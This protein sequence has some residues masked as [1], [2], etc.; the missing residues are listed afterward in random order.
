MVYLP[1]EQWKVLIT[2]AHEGYTTWEEYEENQ[3][4]ITRNNRCTSASR[5]Y[6]PRE[7]PALLQGLALCGICGARLTVRYCVHGGRPQPYYVCKGAGK[8][9]SRSTC[10]SIPGE[11]IDAAIGKLLCEVVTPV[12]LEVALAVQEELQAR[13]AEADGLRLKQVQRHQ[14]EVD[15]ARQRYMKIDPNNR[16]VADA[17]EGDWNEKLRM[18]TASREEYERRRTEDRLTFDTTKQARIRALATDFPRLWRDAK[19]PDRERKRMARLIIEDVTLIKGE[20]IAVHVRFKG[21]ATRSLNLPRPRMSWDRRRVAAEVVKEID[22]Q[23][24]HHTYREVAAILN[25]KKMVSGSGQPFDGKLVMRVARARGLASR[26]RRLRA[27]G[28]LTLEELAPKLGVCTSTVKF[29]R[30]RGRLEVRAY[31]IDDVGRYMYD[32]PDNVLSEGARVTEST[33][34]NSGRGGAV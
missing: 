15:L 27:A 14:Y 23:L 8:T 12:A 13:I 21:G 25:D 4:Q 29:R 31:R 24:D 9:Q 17:L 26:R 28:L 20:A 16:L 11:K 19:T 33:P 5:I 34:V 30:A 18:L 22:R 2:N 6:P 7:G 1:R 32:N 10:Q 3:R